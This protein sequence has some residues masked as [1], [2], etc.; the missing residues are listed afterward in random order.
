MISV[1]NFPITISSTNENCGHGDGSATATA[2]ATC[3]GNF[4]YTWNTSPIQNSQTI[5]NLHAGDYIVTA[6]CSGCSNSATVTVESNPG[7]EA[8][9]IATP[10]V[11]TIENSTVDF[12][13]ITT[14]NIT[15]WYWDLGDGGSSVNSSVQHTY[16]QVGSYQV[17]LV[18][19]DSHGCTDSAI[20]TIVV[21]DYTT[22][23]IPNSFSPNDDGNNDVFTPSG[24]NV[25]ADNFEML[26]YDRWGEL[27]YQTKKW[28]TTSCEGWNG[29][30]N[31]GH[32]SDKAVTG[33][34]V[35]KIHAG[36]S[37][38]GYKNYVGTV[39]L[40]P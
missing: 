7:P 22:L 37:I 36:N 38:S 4:N 26:I 5:S 24:V 19:T 16:P 23:Y 28:L 40:L 27:V 32:N 30:K 20:K 6:S 8:N 1:S 11:I 34:Y 14:G 18:I 33:I 29:T 12:T 15:N 35:F 10:Q 39:T 9:F 13:S 21:H 2:S 31:N 25:D 17:M 3:S